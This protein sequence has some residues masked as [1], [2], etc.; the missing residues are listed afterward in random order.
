MLRLDRHPLGPRVYVLGTRVHEWHLGAALLLAVFA[1][2]VTDRLELSLATGIAALAGLWLVAKDWRD[3]SP[4]RR[5]TAEWRLGLHGRSAPLR[6]ARRADPLPRLAALGA[7]LGGIVNLASAVTPNI[8]WRSHLLLQ[9]APLQALRLSHAVAVPASLLLLA[10]APYLWRRRLGALHLAVVLLTSLAVLDLLKGLDVEAAA[11][12]IGLAT[13]LWLGRDSFCVRHDPVTLRSTLRLILLVAVGGLMLCGLAVWI[14]AP[15]DAS[16]AAVARETVAALLWQQGPLDFHEELGGV[17]EAIGAFGLMALAGCFGL[18]LR[19]LTAPRA[20]PDVDVRRA[21]RRLVSRHG[22]DTLAYF[23]LRRDQHYLFSADRKAFVGYRVEAGVLLVSGDPVGAPESLPALFRA[24]GAFAEV[25][26]LKLA[27]VGAGEALLPLWSQ[28]GLRSRYLG[29]EG[30]VD[31][32]AFSLE[33]R[34]IRKV[35]QSVSRLEKAGYDAVLVEVG[36]LSESALAELE[37][38]S[39]RWRQGAGERGFAMSLDTVR[40]DDHG[41]SLVLLA[42]DGDGRARGYLHFAP[43]YGRRA[44]SLS[45]MRRD[46]DTPNGLTEFMVVRAIEQLRARAVGEVSL[47]FAVFARLIHDPHGRFERLAGRALLLADRFF[48]I[49]RLYRFNAKFFPRW[50]PRYLVYERRLGFPRAGLAALWAEGQLPKPWR[51]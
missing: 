23:K 20:L 1:G 41:D 40:R 15:E 24:L 14:A 3:L 6:T 18:L 10:T 7:L 31:T 17:D 44:V 29:D 9:V 22:A 12:S 47:N 21:V 32:A 19:P 35:R 8:G 45:L 30:I 34:A 43:S 16:L 26:G 48:Q 39:R 33:G 2:G 27:A 5:D 42:R 50:E 28:L 49:E 13:I 36:A 25:R 37:A 51:R 4:S 11:G 38:I 46:H